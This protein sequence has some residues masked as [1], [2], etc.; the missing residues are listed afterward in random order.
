[1]LLA[2]FVTHTKGSALALKDERVALSHDDFAL[3]LEPSVLAAMLEGN[4]RGE[5]RNA[6]AAALQRSDGPNAQ[7]RI[8]CSLQRPE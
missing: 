6:C 1:M 2:E 7:N 4:R 5:L 8:R 3:A